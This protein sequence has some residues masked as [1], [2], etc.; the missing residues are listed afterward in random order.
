MSKDRQSLIDEAVAFHVPRYAELP[1]MGLYLEQV[2]DVVNGSLEYLDH[3]KLTKPMISNYIKN[4]VMASPER[5]RYSRD[6]LCYLIVIDI[7]K[8][9]FTLQQIGEFLEVQKSTYPLEVAY[10]YF[11]SEFENA[12]AEAFRFT[13]MPLPSIESKRTEQTI[14]IRSLVL[15]AAN[16]VFAEKAFLS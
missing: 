15:T 12:L 7:L 13:G 16:R 6:H 11:C 3:G 1:N 9:V 8:P 14:L 4:G 2:L 5:K 10:D